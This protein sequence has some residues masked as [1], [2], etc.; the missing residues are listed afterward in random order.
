IFNTAGDGLMLEFPVA[1][2]AVRVAL[3]LLDTAIKA[4]A[5]QPRLRLGV[6]LGEVLIEGEDLLGH[7]VNVAARLMQRAMPNSVVISEAVKAQLHGEIKA[8][9]EPCGRVQLAKMSEAV[10]AYECLPGASETTKRWRRW[11]RPVM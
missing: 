7:G 9:F 10:L 11:R 1:S 5:E 8:T 4:P 6:H 2:G 3:A